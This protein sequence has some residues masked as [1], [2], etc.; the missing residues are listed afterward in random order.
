MH[1]ACS[2]FFSSDGFGDARRRSLHT[3]RLAD[4]TSR[5]V[6]RSVR[7]SIRQRLPVR[8]SVPKRRV[9]FVSTLRYMREAFRDVAR[10]RA[11]NHTPRRARPR[12]RVSARS[13]RRA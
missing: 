12:T 10:T 13:P 3:R 11:S 5:R 6:R 9:R 4:E 7:A 8:A 2:G 1:A